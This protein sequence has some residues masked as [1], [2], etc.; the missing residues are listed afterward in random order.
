MDVQAEFAL[1][2]ESGMAFS[3]YC[4]AALLAAAGLWATSGTQR[5][6]P[7][8]AA[9]RLPGCADVKV[10][11]A[12][13]AAQPESAEAIRALAQA[14]VDAGQ[15]GLALTLIEGGR[16]SARS[17]LDVLHVYARALLDEGHDVDA[18]T[19]ENRVIAACLPRRDGQTPPSRCNP[20]LFASAMRRADI[21]R[22]L[23]A[24]GVE[25]ARAHPEEALIAYQNATREAR[26]IAQ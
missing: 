7:L 23:V 2:T 22:E 19:V 26:A 8:L 9:D 11:E 20:A 24:R 6:R 10:L 14:Y 12:S 5:E 18:L 3:S 4:I 1:R 25:D 17:D 13:A 16:P 15:P 21:L